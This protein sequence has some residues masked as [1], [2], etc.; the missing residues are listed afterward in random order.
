[1]P[2]H[3][4]IICAAEKPTLLTDGAVSAARVVST[5]EFELCA[6]LTDTAPTDL[7]GSV[8]MLPYGGI[9]ADLA[10]VDIFPGV[11]A[12]VYLWGWPKSAIAPVSISHA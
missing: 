8:P 1:M 3:D 7:R 5:Q 12:S 6:T 11:G 10:L 9:A 4:T 2:K